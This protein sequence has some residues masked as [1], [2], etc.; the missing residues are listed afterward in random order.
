MDKIV[1][2]DLKFPLDYDCVNY[3]SIYNTREMQRK[4]VLKNVIIQI[5]EHNRIQRKKPTLY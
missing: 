3:R 2:K 1:K 5:V 4:L